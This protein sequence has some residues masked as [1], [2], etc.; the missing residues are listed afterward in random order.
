[1]RLFPLACLAAL[2][3]PALPAAAQSWP[4]FRNVSFDAGLGVSYGPEYPGAE[5]NEASP[6]LILRDVR[7]GDDQGAE[8]QGFSL[9]PSFNYI[10]DRESDDND[11]L[12]GLDDIDAAGELGL[13]LNYVSGPFTSYGTLRHGFGGHHG[14]VGELGTKYRIDA[15]ERLTLWT[16][17]EL[18]LGDEDFTD[19]YF[20]VSES[21]SAGS[22]YR[23]YNP[24]GGLYAANISVEARYMLTP[25]TSL[26]GKISYGRLMGDAAD[27]P[28]VE[29]KNQP[30]ISIG[31]ARRLNF[32]F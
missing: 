30:S 32:R 17:A 8:K 1:M 15:T 23:A 10:G 13:K 3:A 31:L 25:K 11:H 4:D 19:T 5:D 27:S 22:G 21:E 28:V 29:D 16:G 18:A 9:V 7:F 14:F 24:D 20:G 2:A 26:N 12:T 6:W